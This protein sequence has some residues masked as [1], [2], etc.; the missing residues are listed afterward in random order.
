M[1]LTARNRKWTRA[2][3]VISAGLALVL[4][5]LLAWLSTQY[6]TAFDWTASGRNSLSE[7]SLAALAA[8]ERDVQFTIFAREDRIEGRVVGELVRRYQAHSARLQ[9][10][11]VN[12]DLNPQ[13][14]RTLGVTRA[15]TVRIQ[16]GKRSKLVDRPSEQMLTNALVELTRIHTP[17]VMHL[18]GHGERSLNGKANHELGLLGATLSAK[19][20]K[21]MPL[22][23]AEAGA[24]PNNIEL[25]V[26]ASPLVDLLDEEVAQIQVFVETGG[27][28]LWLLDPGPWRG[29]EPLATHL[30]LERLPG[31][32]IDQA[33]KQF[34]RG[35]QGAISYV[36]VSKY[37]SHPTVNGFKL[38]TVFPGASAL[39]VE[40]PANFKAAPLL[41]SSVNVW[42]ELGPL[43]GA[44]TYDNDIEKRGP[45]ALGFA[46]ARAVEAGEQRIAIIGDGD[47]LSNAALGNSGNLDLGLRLVEWLVGADQLVSIPA[48]TDPDNTLVLNNTAAAVIGLSFLFGLP[49]L[50]CL[51]ALSVWLRRKNR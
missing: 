49:L 42:A 2:A 36:L 15:G 3:R 37:G 40:P 50:L 26:I 19:G 18:T 41:M 5:A 17:L 48:R 31:T 6:R 7:T 32:L 30:G 22:A 46:L 28:L 33:A 10:E 9:I 38:L 39:E 43:K 1:Q 20:I 45:F 14:L 27:N 47:F 11:Y 16:Y 25:L 13:A 24:V 23:L 29:L 51:A 44:V 8:L 35:G 4:C 12:P 34:A 21:T